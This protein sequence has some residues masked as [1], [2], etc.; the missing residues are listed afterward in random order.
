MTGDTTKASASAVEA[1]LAE[2]VA[3]HLAVD[4]ARANDGRQALAS[5]LDATI[6]ETQLLITLAAAASVVRCIGAPEARRVAAL[7][8]RPIDERGEVAPGLE[9][10]LS[11]AANDLASALADRPL[12]DLGVAGLRDALDQAAR[13]SQRFAGRASL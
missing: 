12:V 13:V 9:A 5:C 3:A 1:M 7:A 11:V 10:A 4:V 6:V 8:L 2:A